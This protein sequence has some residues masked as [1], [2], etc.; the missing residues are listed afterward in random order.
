[1][2][3]CGRGRKGKEYFHVRKREKKSEAKM[4]WN[5]FEGVMVW[6]GGYT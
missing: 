1:M 5:E 3:D 6:D 2:E 4:V